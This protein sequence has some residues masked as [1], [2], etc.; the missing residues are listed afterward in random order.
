[1]SSYPHPLIAREGWPFI[2]LALGLALVVTSLAG[3]LWASPIWL[4]WLFCV[5]F[6]R[7][8]A[9]EVAGNAKSVVAPADGRIVAIEPVRDTDR[10][11]SCRERV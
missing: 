3:L 8:P 5:Q 2:A 9:R 6:F 7:D 1:M 10:K 4:V 11:T